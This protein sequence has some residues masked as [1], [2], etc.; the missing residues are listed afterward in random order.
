[1]DGW[2]GCGAEGGSWRQ[3]EIHMDGQ[4]GGQPRTREPLLL[5]G[6]HHPVGSAQLAVS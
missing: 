6:P 5:G 4:Q 2:Q 1:M 3:L